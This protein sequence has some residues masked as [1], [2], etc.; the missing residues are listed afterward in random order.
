VS[1]AVTSFEELA[2]DFDARVRRIVWCTFATV[3]RRGRPRSRILHPYWEGPIG[4]ILTGRNTL[5]TRHLAAN[6]WVSCAYWDPQHERVHAECRAEWVDDVAEK[7]RI[8][9]LFRAAAPPYGY[10]PIAFWPKGP[11]DADTG[12]L[13]LEPWRI[14]LWLSPPGGVSPENPFLVSVWRRPS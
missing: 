2:A 13:R 14:E 5:K 1:R 12:L 10:D 3:D 9:E 6:P 11:E 4:W 7:R 8:W